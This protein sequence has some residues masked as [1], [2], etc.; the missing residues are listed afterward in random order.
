MGAAIVTGVDAPPVLQFG[1]QVLDQVVF[2]ADRL[3]I[4][5]LHLAVGFWRD[6]G[7][8]AARGQ[9]TAKP[10]AVITFVAQQFLGTW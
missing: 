7:A 3:V 10:V 2:L 8:D 9:S 5:I 1:E 4:V 6:A